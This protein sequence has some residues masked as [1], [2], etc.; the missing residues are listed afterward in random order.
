M[1][2]FLVNFSSG[3]Q[4]AWNINP[5]FHI[6]Y[7]RKSGIKKYSVESIGLVMGFWQLDRWNSIS[8]EKYQANINSVNI[9]WSVNCSGEF[10]KE[11]N[12]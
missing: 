12:K 3:Y 1:W 6:A 2:Q 5:E 7:L 8:A 11:K 4:I 9:Y 10:L